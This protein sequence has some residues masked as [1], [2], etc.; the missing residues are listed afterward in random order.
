MI[1]GINDEDEDECVVCK[2]GGWEDS[3][4]LGNIMYIICIII[5]KTYRGNL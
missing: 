4:L 3:N 1:D 5:Q 2:D